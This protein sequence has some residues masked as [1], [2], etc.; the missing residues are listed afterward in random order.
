MEKRKE[1]I[2]YEYFKHDESSVRFTLNHLADTL[3]KSFTPESVPHFLGSGDEY[4]LSDEKMSA[5][6]RDG[7]ELAEGY[8]ED[9]EWGLF[10]VE[11]FRNVTSR[12]VVRETNQAVKLLDWIRGQSDYCIYIADMWIEGD[13]IW[14]KAEQAI[15]EHVLGWTSQLITRA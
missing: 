5:V 15:K 12:V 13:F 3:L 10:S 7:N 14:A 4:E 8:K 2:T 9:D 6:E 1:G 11:Q